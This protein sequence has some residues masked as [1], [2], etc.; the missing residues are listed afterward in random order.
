MILRKLEQSEHGS[1]RPLW[2]EV[3]AD[4][5]KAFL[6]YYYYIKT[7][8]NE[9]YVVEEDGRICSM[10]QLNPYVLKVEASEL[11]SA[12]IIAV[13]TIEE[14]RGRGYMGGLLRTSL[15]EM[16]AKK[17]PFTFLMPAAEA[18]YS[19]YD[20]RFIY[21]QNIGKIRMESSCDETQSCPQNCVFS[22]AAL[23][24]AEEMARFFNA[25]FSGQWQ[26][27]AV[28]DAAYYQTMIMEQQSEKGGVRLIRQD[29]EIRGMY[30]YAAEAG[31]EIR[32]PLYLPG[33]EAAYRCS[34]QELLGSLPYRGGANGT[35]REAVVYACG[36]SERNRQK[37]VIMARIVRLEELLKAMT[38]PKEAEMN[39]SFAVIDP[40]IRGNSRVWRITSEAGETKIHVC[41][42]EDS[43]GVLPVDVLTEYLFGRKSIA[44][45]AEEEGVMVTER[46]ALE[47]EKITKLT[48]IFLNEIV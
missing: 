11:P 19:P 44:E 37:P 46:L 27:C 47:L 38:V 39:C 14:Y 20:F 13:A 17:I 10:L 31:L 22:D 23:W 12:Y 34:V 24:D 18:I 9:I 48:R 33:Y 45:T 28:R 42:T 35:D 41:E 3:F 32:E 15:N 5:T 16:Y 1:T 36:D 2:E 43:E 30:A 21:E 4:D 8:D 25:Y 26:V 6:D 7:R 40:L 29:G